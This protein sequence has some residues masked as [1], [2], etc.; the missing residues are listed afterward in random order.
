ME[1]FYSGKF[2]PSAKDRLQEAYG[3][4]YSSFDELK[5]LNAPLGLNSSNINYYMGIVGQN[6]I[7]QKNTRNLDKRYMNI[8]GIDSTLLDDQQ[9][10]NNKLANVGKYVIDTGFVNEFYPSIRVPR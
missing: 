2:T 3:K 4:T 6:P 1:Q 10:V 5:S 8:S 9:K 7:V